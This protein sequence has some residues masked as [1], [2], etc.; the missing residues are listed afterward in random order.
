MIT[1]IFSKS[2]PINFLIVFV[3]TALA[4]LTIKFKHIDAP[5]SSMFIFEQVITFLGL[6]F[7]IL[8][9]NFIAS[10]NDLT[11]KSNLE[12]V[13]FSFFLLL[14]PESLFSAKVIW[15]N[16]FILLAVRRLVS[17]RTKKRVKA[18]LFDAAMLI[19][20]AALFYFWAILF[21]LLIPLILLFHSDDN[22]KH[23]VIPF[24]GLMTLFI[25]CVGA[26]IVMHDGYF[27][28]FK[29]NHAICLDLSVYNTLQY[30]VS[31]AIMLVFGLW[32]SFSYVSSIK[33]K[34]SGLRPG[35]KV[36]FAGM[37]IAVVIILISPNK[38]GSDFLFLFA[39]LVIVIANYIELIKQKWIKE[40]FF[41]VLLITPIVFLVLNFLSVS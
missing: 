29:V 38:N 2:K 11:P 36:V 26:S 37:F 32:S 9:L 1:S 7:S 31:T 28:F 23:W 25:L 27:R 16:F 41:S 10:K 18:K 30:I 19:G 20:I 35:F 8:V 22:I 34:T 5:V 12:I 40:V 14:L 15:A 4:F 13:L 17:L 33:M 21:F 6:Y 39:P 24:V 3:I